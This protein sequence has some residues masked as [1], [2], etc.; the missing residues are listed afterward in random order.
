MNR[1]RVQK[2]E[3]I[4]IQPQCYRTKKKGNNNN[5]TTASNERNRWVRIDNL[6]RKKYTHT[7]IH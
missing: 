3:R 7:H 2:T 4:Q 5:S 6:T 1:K